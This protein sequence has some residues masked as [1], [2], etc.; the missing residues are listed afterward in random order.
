MVCVPISY[1]DA[2]VARPIWLNS[3]SE[4]QP[5]KKNTASLSTVKFA[6]SRST[7]TVL[8]SSTPSSARMVCVG[9]LLLGSGFF[10]KWITCARKGGLV[11]V[12]LGGGSLGLPSRCGGG[13]AGGARGGARGPRAGGGGRGGGRGEG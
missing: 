13:A 10:M 12:V 7:G 2:S 6:G 8:L 3:R 11:S 1:K 4:P 9:S 5:G